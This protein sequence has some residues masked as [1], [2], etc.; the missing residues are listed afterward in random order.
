MRPEPEWWADA[1][2]LKGLP[3]REIG[4]RLRKSY[5]SVRY[6]LSEEAR[7]ESRERK[8][9]GQFTGGCGRSGERYSR[10]EF[11]RAIHLHDRV[12]LSWAA[13]AYRLGRSENTLLVMVGR[14]RAGKIKFAPDQ[15]KRDTEEI[16]EQVF[17]GMSIRA[18]ARQRGVHAAAIHQRLG[19]SGIDREVI[20]EERAQRKLAA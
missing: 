6:A 9:K 8:F 4:K 19:R 3:L 18:V 12:G 5:T 13:V 11:E 10:E 1:R 7:R 14:Y 17:S 2:E 16:A 15:W 20:E